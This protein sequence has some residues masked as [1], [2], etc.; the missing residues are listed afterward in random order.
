MM[1]TVEPGV[2]RHYEIEGLQDRM[3]AAV[4]SM[5]ANVS[6]LRPED[7]HPVDEFH[8]G[9]VAATRD[10]LARIGLGPGA[11]LLD[12]GSGVGGPARA[13]AGQTGAHVTGIDLTESYVAI[14]NRLSEMTGMGP[15]TRFVQGSAL[16]MP[17][18]PA[19]FD[20]AMMLHVG[21]NIADKAGLMRE[22]AR[23][24][25][26]G[27]VFAVYDV[28][29][30]AEGQIAYPVPWAGT[31]NLSFV[32]T[33]DE[34]RAAASAAGLTQASERSRRDFAISFFADMRARAAAAQAEGRP[35]PAGIGLIMG[36]DAP[37]K[38]GNLIAAIQ[39][40]TTAPVE[41]IF[42]RG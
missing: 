24:L 33:P 35:P 6:A 5:G 15:K 25:K 28:M 30:L 21:M 29:R 9:G 38:I 40:G 23:V 1:A 39:G 13:A 20:A 12:V 11:Q 16:A 32:A 36:A 18:G 34:Y 41:L 7:L 17:F 2:A 22:V 8:I 10:V 37:T 42:R 19:T 4:A 3:L 14:A 27:G 26:P 31:E